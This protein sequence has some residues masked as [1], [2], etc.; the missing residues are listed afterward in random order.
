V[1]P[2]R[3]AAALA[4]LAIGFGI[5][6][7]GVAIADDPAPGALPATTASPESAPP[8]PSTEPVSA[9]SSAPEVTPAEAVGTDNSPSPTRSDPVNGTSSDEFPCSDAA[10]EV[11]IDELSVQE[12]TA[13]IAETDLFVR[14]VANRLATFGGRSVDEWETA[15]D[16][17][18]DSFGESGCADESDQVFLSGSSS[19]FFCSAAGISADDRLF[20]FLTTAVPDRMTNCSFEPPQGDN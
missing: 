15:L 4:A 2:S 5:T 9:G 1:N 19:Q 6:L 14:V 3:L 8:L 16:G 18:F 17:V 7:M 13:R 10:F 11:L 20:L 12:T